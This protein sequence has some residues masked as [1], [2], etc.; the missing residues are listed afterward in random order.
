[1]L[2]SRECGLETILSDKW[3][4][5]SHS[6]PRLHLRD[7]IGVIISSQTLLGQNIRPSDKIIDIIH[8]TTGTSTRGKGTE[9]ERKAS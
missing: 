7:V 2:H 8:P 1:M 3:N 4:P 9:Q 5:L 6:N